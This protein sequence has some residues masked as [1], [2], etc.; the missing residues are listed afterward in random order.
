[1]IRIYYIKIVFDKNN[2]CIFHEC[3]DVLMFL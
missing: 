3:N 2:K 1:M